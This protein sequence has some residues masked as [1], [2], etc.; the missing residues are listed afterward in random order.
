MKI[1]IIEIIWKFITQISS[2]T[3]SWTSTGQIWYDSVL[4][5]FRWQKASTVVDLEWWGWSSSPWGSDTQVQFNDWGVFWGVASFIFN[6]VTSLLT[7]TEWYFTDTLW[8]WKTNDWSAAIDVKSLNAWEKQ[9]LRIEGD[10]VWNTQ[11]STFLT[12]DLF[13]RFSFLTDW[14]MKW[15]S[16][17]WAPDTNLFRRIEW[18]LRTDNDFEASSLTLPIYT[19]ALPDENNVTIFW[20]KIWERMMAA[21][22]WPS[23]LDASI[24]PHFWRNKIW[25]TLPQWNGTVISTMGLTLTATG[26]A[27]AANVAVTNIHTMM[28]RLDYLVTTAATTAVAGFRYAAAQFAIWHASSDL[29]WGFHMVCRWWPATGVATTTNRAFVGMRNSTAAPTDVEPS[30]V[31]NI[32]WM[33]WDAADTNIQIMHRGTGA[34][35]KIDLGANFPVPTADRTEVYDIALFSPPWTTQKVGWEVIRVS[36]GDIASWEITT[37]L[38]LTTVLLAPQWYM[39]VWGTSS[40]IWI[41]LMSMYIETYY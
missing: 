1:W 21:F 25:F 31:T 37:N 34:V 5:K 14:L 40:V 32:V 7:V 29:L 39:S 28:R 2:G 17:T 20:R 15:S 38:P 6:K 16:W 13:T 4:D 18:V 23:W 22:M 24:Q 41:A 30:S 9:G 26:T 12:G 19:P 35:T 8:V 27:T 11:F 3:P 33:G 10:N 36:T